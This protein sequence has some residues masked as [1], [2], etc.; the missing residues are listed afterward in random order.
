MYRGA[1]HS[2]A[3][4]AG[5]TA[6]ATGSGSAT[7]TGIGLLIGPI[8]AYSAYCL[9]LRL[10]SS[11]CVLLRLQKTVGGKTVSESVVIHINR[12]SSLPGIL[13][14]KLSVTAVVPTAARERIVAALELA[15]HLFVGG[16]T[17]RYQHHVEAR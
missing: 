7:A 3:D 6:I 16:A 2:T 15:S 13:W 8:V 11:R 1:A 9:I 12:K 14:S 4:A 17:P 10:R 5:C